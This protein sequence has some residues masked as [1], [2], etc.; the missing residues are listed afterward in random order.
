MSENDAQQAFEESLSKLREEKNQMEAALH[1]E[2]SRVQAQ[3]WT[4]ADYPHHLK[5]LERENSKLRVELQL[6]QQTVLALSNEVS[7]L[8]DN[9]RLLKQAADGSADKQEAAEDLRRS[10]DLYGSVT[11]S[12][13]ETTNRLMS[14]LD[15]RTSG[16]RPLLQYYEPDIPVPPGIRP[17][18]YSQFEPPEEGRHP[19]L[20]FRSVT[21]D[22][23]SLFRTASLLLLGNELHHMSLREQVVRHIKSN[24]EAYSQYLNIPLDTYLSSLAG[25]RPGDLLALKS[26]S[27][28]YRALITVYF[29]PER[30]KLLL[31]PSAPPLANIKLA[32]WIADHA[33]VYCGIY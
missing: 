22:E 25:T 31:H 7:T 23:H 21:H 17:I 30:R 15:P 1:D 24:P 26:I 12:L 29:L 16:T 19:D 4:A 27:D 28:R 8:K 6:Q 9:N 2:I 20:S 10:V 11:S 3:K 13:K 33:E 32:M 5:L 18:I 14:S